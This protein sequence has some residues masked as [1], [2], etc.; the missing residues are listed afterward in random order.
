[1]T[2]PSTPRPAD[3][4][5]LAALRNILL[6]I[7]VV[8]VVGVG[9][10]LLLLEHF[11]EPLQFVPFAL[12]AAGIV[13]VVAVLLQPSRRRL[14]ALRIVMLLCAVSGVVGSVLHLR[15]NVEFELEIAPTKS[16]GD[17]LWKALRGGSPLLAPGVMILVAALASAATYSFEQRP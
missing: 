3:S 13:T 16:V 4:A 8:G 1:M 6:G 5:T 2:S 15:A 9:V 17:V 11:E 12:A 14:R 7:L 10:E